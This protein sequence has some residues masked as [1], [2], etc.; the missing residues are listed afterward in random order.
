M[1]EVIKRAAHDGSYTI[2]SNKLL[3]D[4][5]LS[6]EAR[7]VLG[8]LLSKPATWKIRRTDLVR[9]SP[10]GET[11]IRRVLKELETFGYLV[12]RR[13]RTTSGAFDYESRI[14]EEPP[15]A[16]VKPADYHE[17]L[18]SPEWA[19]RRDAALKRVNFRCQLCNTGGQLN[20]HH[21]T[22]E[23]VGNEANIDLVVLCRPCHK[24]YHGIIEEE[25]A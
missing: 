19:I 13:I 2:I 20:V 12:R 21:R 18:T 14:Y 15:R 9:Q 16:T 10:A 3:T 24:T 25:I 5:R 8:Y 1:S 4:E 11:K 22:Y 23:R 7:G 6:W 17:Y